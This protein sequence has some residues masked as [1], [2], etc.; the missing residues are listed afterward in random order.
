MGLLLLK[1]VF[2]LFYKQELPFQFLVY[3]GIFLL[4]IPDLLIMLKI[5]LVLVQE[6]IAISNIKPKL[7]V[8]F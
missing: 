6:C 3:Q 5:W 7:F 2:S 4:L 1:T 8:H